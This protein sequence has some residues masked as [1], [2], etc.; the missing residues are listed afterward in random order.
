MSASADWD[1]AR[2]LFHRALDLPAYERAVFVRREAGADTAIREQVES[3]LAAHDRADGFLSQGAMDGNRNGRPR[4]YAPGTRLGAFEIVGLLGTGGMGEVYR[5][6]DTRL[7]REVA[8]KLLAGELAADCCVARCPP[9]R[10]SRSRWRCSTRS[11]RRT[12]PASS[13]AI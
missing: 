4:R 3:L 13:I 6:R 9:A 5:A 10:R 8:I 2:D 11:R 1:R 7:G 12:R